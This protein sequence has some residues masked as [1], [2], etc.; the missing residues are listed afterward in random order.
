P[1]RGGLGGTLCCRTAWSHTGEFRR[2]RVA[3]VRSTG[4]L[5]TRRCA[6]PDSDRVGAARVNLTVSLAG[7]TN[8]WR[9]RGSRQLEAWLASRPWLDRGGVRVVRVALGANVQEFADAA[10]R[11]IR[12][13][14]GGR[15]HLR[16]QRL[17]PGRLTEGLEAAV[18]EALELPPRL[19]RRA[20]LDQV[21]HL[22]TIRPL[23][24]LA[25]AVRTRNGVML[26]DSAATIIE[27]L[28]KV[29]A[30]SRVTVPLFD[31][32][33]GL[34][35]A[36]S[37]DFS[38]GAPVHAT[39]EEAEARLWSAY[40]HARIAW[41]AAGNLERARRWDLDASVGSLPAG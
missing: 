17:E 33:E 34:P 18:A 35:A 25:D 36:D 27:E 40:L 37:L 20:Y 2:T 10:V 41:E 38:T 24:F 7:H 26:A 19:G 15:S 6:G 23:V 30:T 8:V 1:D 4:E 16:P 9:F 39:L 12:A 29:K 22:M 32:A 14:D 5:E 21:A 13:E 28:A 11:A 31:D 3:P